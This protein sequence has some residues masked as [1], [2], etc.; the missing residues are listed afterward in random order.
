[1]NRTIPQISADLE[2]LVIRKALLE[3]ELLA[4]RSRHFECLA[5]RIVDTVVNP[6]GPMGPKVWN[7][8]HQAVLGLLRAPLD[9][10]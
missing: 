9:E 10:S 6:V 7:D 5:A 4:A 1:M 2:Q 8:A 3:E